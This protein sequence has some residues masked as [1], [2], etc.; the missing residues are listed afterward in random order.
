[1]QQKNVFKSNNEIFLTK[2]SLKMLFYQ[3]MK[4]KTMK[5][6]G[7]VEPLLTLKLNACCDKQTDISLL[8]DAN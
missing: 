4:R 1:M 8:Y 6:G 2:V 5:K 3:N 7:V